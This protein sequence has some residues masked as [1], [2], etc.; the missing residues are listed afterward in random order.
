MT[1][2]SP[3]LPPCECVEYVQL[4]VEFLHKKA[5]HFKFGSGCNSLLFQLQSILCIVPYHIETVYVINEI[6]LSVGKHQGSSCNVYFEDA[7]IN[8]SLG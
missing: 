4:H 5:M 6:S 8:G 7:E 1:Y 2:F 3:M